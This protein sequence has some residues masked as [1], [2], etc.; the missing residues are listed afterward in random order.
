[1]SFELEKYMTRNIEDKKHIILDNIKL[2]NDYFY[3]AFAKEVPFDYRIIDIVM[4]LSNYKIDENEIKYIKYLNTIDIDLLS[5]IACNSKISMKRLGKMTGI[6]DFELKKILAKLEK[7]KL[8][9]KV[10]NYSYSIENGILK[11]IPQ[12]LISY[13]LK[14]Y[15]WN[16]ALEQGIY[17]KR[18]SEYSFVILDKSRV[19][20]NKKIKF[21]YK[22]NNVG[23]MFLDEEDNIEV[24]NMP[25]VNKEINKYDNMRQKIKFLKDSL[26]NKKWMDIF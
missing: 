10:S 18:F 16:E 26:N 1:M 21:I 4:A 24:I 5:F 7:K 15:N 8:I 19:Y 13:E 17:N 12:I 3:K 25:R 14:L 20:E 23:L 11:F 2:K 22:E 6:N 9:K